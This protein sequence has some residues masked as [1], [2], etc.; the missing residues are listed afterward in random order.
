[1]TVSGAWR[2]YGGPSHQGPNGWAVG[3]RCSPKRLTRT[4]PLAFVQPSLIILV[5]HPLVLN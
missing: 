2:R 1:M 3:S 4:L 5:E